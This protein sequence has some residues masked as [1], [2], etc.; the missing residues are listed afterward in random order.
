MQGQRQVV[1]EVL[2]QIRR[3]C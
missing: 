1:A 3:S 2:Q